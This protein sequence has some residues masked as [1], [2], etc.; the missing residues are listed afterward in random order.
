MVK[1]MAINYSV[2]TR[3]DNESLDYLLQCVD[4]LLD[5]AKSVAECAASHYPHFPRREEMDTLV[6]LGWT[7][8]NPVGLND[9]ISALELRIS[10]IMAEH[11]L[12]IVEDEEPTT[13]ET[14]WLVEHDY[15][16]QY[17]GQFFS[18]LCKAEE[19]FEVAEVDPQFPG[20]MDA[21]MAY[22]TKNIKYPSRAQE[23]N[24]KGTV[25]VRFVVSKTG[26]VSNVTVVKALDPDCDKEAVRVISKMPRWTPAKQSGK[27]V[28][29]YYQ[30][31]VRFVL[32]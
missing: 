18:T 14:E 12:S 13:H 19:I 2:Q 28:N 17:G 15:L 16:E 23:N 10:A 21:L 31:P 29:V 27:P 11:G 20:G 26:D 25:V 8:E 7:W 22:L 24:I 32:Q 1:I 9:L 5:M 4:T 6:D 3:L 30:V